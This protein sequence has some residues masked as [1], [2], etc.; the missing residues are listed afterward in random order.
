MI[1]VVNLSGAPAQARVHLPWGDLRDSAWRL[2][3]RLSD[4]VYDRDG[5]EMSEQGLYV[6]LDPWKYHLF[7]CSRAIAR[8]KGRAGLTSM[9][10]G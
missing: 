9:A 6:G 8:E 10:R 4:I 7:R 3:D 2:Q 1:I 5:V